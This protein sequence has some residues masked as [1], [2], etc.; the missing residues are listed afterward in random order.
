MRPVNADAPRAL[1]EAEA[2]L[3]CGGDDRI[4]LDPLSGLNRYG[5]RP[6]PDPGLRSFAS[7]TAS[8]ISQEGYAAVQRLYDRMQ[9]ED[10]LEFCQREM[11]RI[12]CELLALN[13]IEDLHVELLFC[14]SGTDAHALAAGRVAND[15]SPLQVIMVEEGE[16]GSGVRSVLPQPCTAV[17]LR[18][19][20]GDARC[21]EEIDVQMTACV[22]QA[23]NAGRHV[24]L[25]MADQSKTGLIA[26]SFECVKQ[27][28]SRYPDRLDVLVDACQFRI[29][30]ATLRAYLQLG[31]QVALTGSKFFAG[32]SFS[33]AL[34]LPEKPSVKPIDE[35]NAGL[36]LRWEAA[37]VELRRFHA[38]PEEEIARLM[39]SFGQS[40]SCRLMNDASL[41]M[42]SVPP[43]VRSV[44]G[45]DAIQSIYPFLI[46]GRHGLL[47]RPAMHALYRALRCQFGQPVACGVREGRE[48]SAMRLC[49][50]AK[51]VSDAFSQGSVDGVVGEAMA[52]LDEAIF[53]AQSGDS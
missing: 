42:L 12:R 2:L 31:C 30:P 45:W 26:P 23:V 18:E 5:C 13:R 15:K 20:N 22:E 17:R 48:V 8:T 49:L 53:L 35:A 36:L 37:M 46:R 16:T 29:K 3:I 6:Y 10:G 51:Q 19:A 14:A 44:A 1:S 25:I 32:P 4:S 27:L 34:L 52:A 21:A 9:R 43:L 50:S 7:S 40:I 24:L 41:E 47:D 39:A 33:G 38:V 28:R 11:Q